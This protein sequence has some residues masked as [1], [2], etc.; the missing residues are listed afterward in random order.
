MQMQA[1]EQF[2][3]VLSYRETAANG[4]RGCDTGKGITTY[5]CLIYS[6]TNLVD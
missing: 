4:G 6:V 3:Y 5:Y 1:T 2:Q